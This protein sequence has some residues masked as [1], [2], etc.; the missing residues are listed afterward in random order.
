MLIKNFLR[1]SFILLIIMAFSF[2]CS[3]TK[4][5]S[6]MISV[7]S[8]NSG[9]ISGISSGTAD[10]SSN[11]NF[12]NSITGS[13]STAAGG[14]S[15]TSSQYTSRPGA[16]PTLSPVERTSVFKDRVISL[17]PVG[18]LATWKTSVKYNAA[19]KSYEFAYIG[20]NTNIKYI[21]NTESENTK[22][23]ML[24]VEAVINNHT[25]FFPVTDGGTVYSTKFSTHGP[26]ELSQISS[27]TVNHGLKDG[28]VVYNYIDSVQNFKTQ[29]TYEFYMKGMT[30]VVEAYSNSIAFDH[31]YIGFSTGKATKANNARTFL[32][33]YAEDVPVIIVDNSFF[34]SAYIDKSLT[35]ATSKI[36]TTFEYPLKD[37]AQAGIITQYDI[38][39]KGEVNPLK[40]RM[41]VTLSEN[42]L[43]CVYLTSAGKSQYRDRLSDM[44]VFEEW[45]GLPMFN[46]RLNKYKFLAETYK[47]NKVLYLDHPWQRDGYDISLPAHFPAAN[48][49]GGGAVMKTFI[50]TMQNNFGWIAAL[51]E[52]YWFMYPS[53]TNQYWNN[54][55]KSRIARDA[56]LQMNNGYLNGNTK[57]QSLAIKAGEMKY[58][59]NKET[60]LIF[61]NYNTKAIYLDVN[62]SGSPDFLKQVT[63]DASSKN[64]RSIGM[65]VSENIDLFKSMRQIH[66][67]PLLGEGYINGYDTYSSIY[68][69]N[70]DGVERE[71][72]GG[73]NADIIPDYELRY[74]RPL[75]ANQ[76][77]GYQVRFSAEKDTNTF[78]W[79]RYN[80]MSIVYGHTGL[81]NNMLWYMTDEKYVSLYYMF[82]AIQSQY[83]N[84]GAN[85]VSIGYFNG[86]KYLNINEAIRAGY[87]FKSPRIYIKYSNGLEIYANFSGSMWNVTLNSKA[88]SLDRDG[89]VAANKSASFLQYS[90][91]VNGKRVDYVDCKSYT[92]ANARGNLTD[93]GTFSTNGIK[94]TRK[95]TNDSAKP[96][97]NGL[98]VDSVTKIGVQIGFTTDKPCNAKLLYGE[99]TPD[100]VIFEP[101]GLNT[102]HT[103]KVVSGLKAGTKYVYKIIAE[104]I[105]GNVTTSAEKSFTTEGVVGGELPKPANVVLN[106]PMSSVDGFSDIQGDYGW[107]YFESV[108]GTYN[109]MQYNSVTKRWKGQAEWCIIDNV[110]QHPDSSDSVRAFKCPKAGK[111]TINA[112]VK[113]LSDAGDG[114]NFAIFK[115]AS[116][117]YPTATSWLLLK[118]PASPA[119][120][121]ITC[122]VKI[123]DMVYFTINN[124]GTIWNDGTSTEYTITYTQ[125]S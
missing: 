27:V 47:I 87:N 121:T 110:S 113:S 96:V 61:D 76:G 36:A 94:L 82:Q 3:T 40:E 81:V 74:I 33:P 42:I 49:L 13:S 35:N 90:C 105:S 60:K 41:Y 50:N 78:I 117:V 102:D 69:G 116:R 104:D 39:S 84:T 37:E 80:T 32:L 114:I 103:I 6:S 54:D 77:M 122:D 79:D 18:A 14:D 99:T 45:G 52:D 118:G 112:K 68:A 10:S 72:I 9:S 91:L 56:A 109:Q 55:G 107:M 21:I 124:A 70:V 20:N 4:G 30:L 48:N 23:G 22:K 119:N 95:D 125:L 88:Y 75:M 25:K 73:K 67:G 24:H 123:N 86:S 64:S 26:E 5:G 98:A 120:V 12:S 57:V 2:G 101:F 85:V 11:S 115:N 89:Y 15:Y 58:Y 71:I 38:N 28:K 108:N 46:D 16:T 34:M 93:F 92:F 65:A 44:V 51:H 7:I 62:T 29:K 43:D 66:N 19:T 106:V 83:L 31:G 17:E 1:I 111:I 63:L 59:A 53:S 100:N 8:G 97:I